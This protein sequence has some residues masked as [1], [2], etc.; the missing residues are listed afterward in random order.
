[1]LLAVDLHED[2]IDVK[3]VAVTSVFS[4]QSPSVYGSKFYTPEADRLSG[5]SDA[6]FGQE[7]FDVSV[8]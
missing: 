5:Y 6:T 2:F 3:G 7:I 4:F 8:A 1:M